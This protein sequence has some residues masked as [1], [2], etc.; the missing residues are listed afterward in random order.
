[1]GVLRVL[2]EAIPRLA[3]VIGWSILLGFSMWLCWY[4]GIYVAHTALAF[5][6]AY[7]INE[8]LNA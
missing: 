8:M 5:N 7:A 6:R 3:A 2:V 4:E 1:M